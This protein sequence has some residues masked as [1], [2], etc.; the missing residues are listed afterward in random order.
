[1]PE[2]NSLINQLEPFIMAC[3]KPQAFSLC[4]EKIELL[5]DQK[6]LLPD[7]IYIGELNFAD[8]L[9]CSAENCFIFL[10]GASEDIATPS[11]PESCTVLLFSCSLAKLYNLVSEAIALQSFKLDD[12]VKQFQ[13]VWVD[14]MERRLFGHAEIRGALSQMQYPLGTFVRV[15]LISFPETGAENMHAALLPRLRNF[16]PSSNMTIYRKDILIF[17]CSEE[18]D[19]RPELDLQTAFSLNTLLEECGGYLMIGNST[20]KYTALS[21][22]YFLVKRTLDIAVQ[23]QAGD[24][25]RILYFED[26]SVYC[27]IDLSIQRYLESKN[28][29]DVL[30]LTHPAIIHITRYDRANHTNLRDVLYYYLLNDRNLVKTASITFMHRNTVLNKIRR[31]QDLLNLDLDDP[32]L[33]QRLIFS[34]QLIR[35]YENVMNREIEL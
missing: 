14:I 10:A 16:F 9:P 13:N 4:P 8:C 5:C 15:V 1:M 23:I 6:A 25:K 29:D 32:N 2:L 11:F 28:N 12:G 17:L 35:Y 31:I 27:V 20:S 30:Y 7:R 19:F 3:F 33:R 24:S 34:C 18:R 22:I 26:F 21:S